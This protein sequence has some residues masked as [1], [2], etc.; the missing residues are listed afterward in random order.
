MIVSRHEAVSVDGVR[1]P[2]TQ[3]GRK[4]ETG[5]VPVHLYGYGGFAV[6]ALPDYQPGLGKLWLE[7]GGTRVVANIR[8]GGEFGTRWHEQGGASGR[9]SR[10]TISPPSPPI[11]WR[12]A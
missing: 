1:I 4:D 10:M 2:Y 3:F 9:C 8:G 5:N 11:S 6:S 7:R 12:A